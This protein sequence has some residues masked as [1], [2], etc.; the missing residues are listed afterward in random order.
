MTLSAAVTNRS[1]VK[2]RGVMTD[3]FLTVGRLETD[4]YDSQNGYN[5][6]LLT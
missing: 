2:M 3:E 5:A 1:P 4:V 6:A